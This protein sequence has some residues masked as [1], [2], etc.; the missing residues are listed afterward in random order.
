MFLGTHLVLYSSNAEADRAFLRDV[1]GFPHVDAGEGWLIFAL[2]P[3]ETGIHPGAG[4]QDGQGTA[5]AT[6]YLM[7]RDLA[8]A[9]AALAAK[10]VR[11]GPIHEA[12]WGLVS[13]I[14]LPG[15]GSLGFY[16]PHHAT[17]I[18]PQG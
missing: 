3:A 7:C 18:T 1:L 14:P 9:I 12:G 17:A 6:V 8:G 16:Q 4:L 11:C 5:A 10:G 2:P 13:S 15:G